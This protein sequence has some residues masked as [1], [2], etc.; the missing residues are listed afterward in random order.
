MSDSTRPASAPTIVCSPWRCLVGLPLL[1]F[2]GILL[3]GCQLRHENGFTRGWADVNSLGAPAAFLMQ[4]RTDGFRPAPPETGL[5]QVNAID[6][7]LN[8][9]GSTSSQSTVFPVQDP[10]D[11]SI[12]SDTGSLNNS[13]LPTGR[14]TVTTGEHHAPHTTIPA[15]EAM[16]HTV[17]QPDRNEAFDATRATQRPVAPTGAWLF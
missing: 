6:I 10:S 9:Y 17:K 1:V 11:E 8:S 7:P 12:T 3:T 4:R 14:P 15:I 16:S 5:P 13:R 2:S